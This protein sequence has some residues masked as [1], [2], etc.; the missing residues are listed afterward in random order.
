MDNK[1]T[2]TLH[3]DIKTVLQLKSRQPL[4]LQFHFIPT[5]DHEGK[6]KEYFGMGRDISEIKAVET[7][8]AQETLRAQEVEVIKNAFLHNMSFEI[9]TPLNAVVGFAELFQMEHSQEDEAV[10]ISEIKENSAKLLRLIND[11]LLL[12]RL[13][14]HMIE[15]NQQTVDFV[16]FLESRCWETWNTSHAENV[17]LHIENPFSHIVLNVDPMYLGI[18]IDQLLSNAAEHTSKGAVTVACD[19]IDQQLL[20]TACHRI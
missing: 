15:F 14:A 20:I 2:E 16:T 3:A 6:L 19:Y 1:S 9:R 4:Y 18:V 7:K 13:D 17:E 5:Y 10:F 11:I 8:L 12:S